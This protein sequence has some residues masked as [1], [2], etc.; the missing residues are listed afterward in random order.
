[1]KKLLTTIVLVALTATAFCQK[2]D[3]PVMFEVNGQQIR[4]SEFMKEF[5]A[6]IGKDPSSPK[7]ACT[8]EKR[9]ALQEYVELFANF[10]A[11][12]ADAKARGFD[13]M[14]SLVNELRQYRNDLAA[15][16]LLDSTTLQELLQEAYDRN[17]Y[18]VRANHILV[19][20]NENASPADTLKAY[21]HATDLYNRVMKGED[22][23][24]L[25]KEE[26]QRTD[27][28]V[29]RDAETASTYVA[30]ELGYFSVFDM[31]Y[32]F[33]T[34]A[35]NLKAGGISKP[36]RTR[37]G[38]HIIKVIDR[39]P[40]YGQTKVQHI[41]VRGGADTI[42]GQKKIQEAYKRLSK[43][44][45]FESVAQSISD[46]RTTYSDGGRLPMLPVTKLPPEYIEKA[47]SGMAEGTYTEPFHTRFGWHIVKLLHKDTIPPYE[48]MVSIYKQRLTRDQRNSKP[49]DRFIVDAKKRYGFKD[50]TQEYAK[51]K[52]GKKSNKPMANMETLIKMV[53]DSIFMKQWEY[54]EAALAA[55]D[56]TLFT[57][58][59]KDYKLTEFA[60]YVKDHQRGELKRDYTEY[61]NSRYKSYTDEMVIKCANDNL[62]RD[63]S[64]FAALINEYR[65][66]LM[67]FAYNEKMIWSKAMEDTA[68]LKAFYNIQRTKRDINNP[69][70]SNYFWNTRARTMVVTIA[71]SSCI[72]PAK[73]I[74]IV[75]KANK[76]RMSQSDLKEMLT[77]SV[78]KKSTIS[79]PIS[80]ALETFEEDRHSELLRNE[81]RPGIYTH[82]SGHGYKIYVV[83]QIT[84]PGLKSLQEARGYYITD[85]Q[86]ELEQELNKRLRQKYNVK[87]HQDVV[88][89][90][91]Y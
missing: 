19:R 69:A 58:N 57:L 50:Y 63:N 12:L 79:N 21:R 85:Y 81:W 38:Y 62:E 30:G 14:P 32:P 82:T 26:E 46:D 4:R 45:S 43:G 73:A 41:W 60:K 72:A 40:F 31:V 29:V 49:K 52:N 66:G 18:I 20:C 91:T 78:N 87:I 68:G 48:D 22:F 74:K 54:D 70:D 35:Y 51:G 10:R 16:Y 67:I 37:F 89:E 15:P 23:T 11:K 42:T 56:Q 28:G 7:T 61:L 6:S 77:K 86:N 25:A 75:E 65:N 39:K 33:E 3:D 71:D 64:D 1:M 76:K 2:T 13:T 88:D 84:N 8:Y 59:G 9:Q 47:A 36:V 34:A 83:E 90:T 55:N 53:N 80:V 17:H 44:E 27:E 5:L 24:A